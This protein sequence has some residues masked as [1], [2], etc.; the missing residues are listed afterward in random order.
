V[1][2]K[3]TDKRLREYRSKRDPGRTPEP[4][5]DGGPEAAGGGR[6]V[7]QEHH[8]RRLHWDLRL[9]HEGVAV[10]WALPK[11]I[12][13]DPKENRLAVHVED[14]PLKYLEFEGDI[15]KGE[16]GAGTIRIWDSGTY[17]AEKFEPEKLIVTF[18]GERVEGKY[19]LFQTKDKNWLIHRMDP[20]A[21]PD[22]EP[23]PQNLRPMLARL[24]KL[25]K[26]EE[27]YAYEI[28]WDGVRALVY[29]D[30]GH[31][32]VQSRTGR[33][34]SDQFPEIRKLGRELGAHKAILDG[35]IVA[36]DDQGKPS[37]QRLQ[38]RIHLASERAVR[39]RMKQTPATYM[40][41]DLLYLD[42]RPLLKTP[43]EARRKQLAELDLAGPSWQTPDH[44]VGEG[45]ALQ[46]ASRRQGLEG[47][48]AKQLDSVYQPGRRS[49]AWLKVKN[50]RSQDV[51]I[52]GWLPGKGAREGRIGALLVGYVEPEDGE[53]RLKYAGRVG[54]G[55]DAAMLDHLASLLEPLRRKA[56]PFDG[57]QPPKES[58]FVEPKLVGEVEFNEWT[59]AGTLRQ[60]VFKGLRDDKR[61]DEAVR[62]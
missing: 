61:P 20:P 45:R 55:F 35:E 23:M 50:V 30:H 33:E 54:T 12:P 21:D 15:P 14:H 13:D 59:S 57:R 41:F 36:M 8:A 5:G 16:Y 46:E 27:S 56:S 31:V 25:P 42:G 10:S 7:I 22:A 43:Y 1:P 34:I 4:A 51:V 2:K 24:A 18:S 47:I 52:G 44:H 26:N 28:K 9:E 6:F 38:G 37:F 53:T 3:K 60:P 29:C 48:V 17:E 19:A 40:I 39:T 49:S 11:G 32:R 58:R 62:E